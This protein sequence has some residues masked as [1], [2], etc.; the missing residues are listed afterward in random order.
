M[1]VTQTRSH[2]PLVVGAG[3]ERGFSLIEALIAML[4]LV[5]G[6][7]A[8]AQVFVLGMLHL[9]GS[10]QSLVAREKAREAIESVHAARDAGSIDWADVTNASAAD[11]CPAGSTPTTG[12][13]FLADWQPL[14]QPGPDNLVNT[15][16]DDGA[17]LERSPGPN[18]IFGDGDDVELTGFER[19]VSICQIPTNTRLRVVVVS[20][21]YR[22]GGTQPVYTATTYISAFA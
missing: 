14:H 8:L 10:S 20:I 9:K 21:R 2:A 7:L 17:A 19:K 1:Q 15:A 16:D 6:L 11:N 5:T 3:E 18:N 4:V 12:G 22:V 13:E